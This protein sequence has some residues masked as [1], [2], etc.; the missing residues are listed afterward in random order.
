MDDLT[1]D[2]LA[3]R[4]LAESYAAGCD[5]RD[6]SRLLPVFVDGGTI[7]VHWHDRE[8]GLM[9]APDDLERIPKGLSRYDRTVHFIG[10]HL[11]DIRG[12]EAS[13]RTYCFA[14]HITGTDDY[15]MSIIYEDECRRVDGAWKIVTRD[16]RLQW[17][18]DRSVVVGG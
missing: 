13:C 4:Y 16:L 15:V 3:L 14:H 1:A 8:P 9:R 2:R 6:L 5:T 7:T 18:A 11:A 10:N 17:T 12:D